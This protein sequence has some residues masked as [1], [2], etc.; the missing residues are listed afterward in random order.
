MPRHWIRISYEDKINIVI[1]FYSF[2]NTRH[3]QAQNHRKGNELPGLKQLA[4]GY[5]CNRLSA[6]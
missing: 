6:K 2:A 3:L 4:K 5:S 1:P